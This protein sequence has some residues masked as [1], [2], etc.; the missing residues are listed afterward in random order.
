MRTYLHAFMVGENIGT[1]ALKL[2]KK[3][4]CHGNYFS[5]LFMN[6]HILKFF[7]GIMML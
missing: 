2:E 1:Y 6:L 5:Q 4:V 7:S 3:D